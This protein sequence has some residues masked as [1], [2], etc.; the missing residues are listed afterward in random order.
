[1]ICPSCGHDNLQGVDECARCQASLQQEGLPQPDSS[2]R[3]RVMVDPVS[4]L[5]PSTIAPQIVPAG[6]P[7]DQGVRRMQEKNVGYLL[8]TNPEGRLVGILTEHDLLCRVAGQVT[9]LSAYRV[10]DFMSPNPTTVLASEPIN[11]ALHYMATNDFMY[12]PI[13]DEAGRPQDLLSF[14]RVARLIEHME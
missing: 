6:T 12:I 3:W 1:M 4:S 5:E 8:V 7:L 2:V 14:R 10:D 11:H 13:V 9:D